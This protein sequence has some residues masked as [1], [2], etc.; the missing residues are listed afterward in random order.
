L[1]FL[2]HSLVEPVAVVRLEEWVGWVVWVAVWVEWDQALAPGVVQPLFRVMIFG[3][4]F[5]VGEA[6]FFVWKE[7]LFVFL[8]LRTLNP[9][10]IFSLHKI[11]FQWN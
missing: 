11:N 6:P 7:P 8:L 1:I 2:K 5:H 9:K 4:I 10:T 3:K